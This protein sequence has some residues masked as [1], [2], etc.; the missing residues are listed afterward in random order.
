M[1]LRMMPPKDFKLWMVEAG[2]NGREAAEA[3]GKST[4]TISRYRIVGVPTTEAPIVR[5]A[6][7][8]VLAKIE[9]WYAPK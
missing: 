6:C 7:A 9:P 2:L 4:D 8:A 3:L 1:M 5:L